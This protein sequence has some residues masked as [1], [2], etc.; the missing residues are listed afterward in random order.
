MVLVVGTGLYRP[1]PA[2]LATFCCEVGT[3]AVDGSGKSGVLPGCSSLLLYTHFSRTNHT[4]QRSHHSSM[5]YCEAQT[6][7]QDSA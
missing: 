6:L 5:Q 7:S 1:L 3:G 4:D 2:P